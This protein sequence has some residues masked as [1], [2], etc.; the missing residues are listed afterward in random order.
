MDE[1][2]TSGPPTNIYGCTDP[3][4]TNHNPIAR[5]NDGSCEYP[6]Y[7]G[8][9]DPTAT[10]F[11]P[12]ARVNDG[13]CEYNHIYGCTDQLATNYNPNA[14][15]DDGSCQYDKVLPKCQQYTQPICV[16]PK[17]RKEACV[18]GNWTRQP[19]ELDPNGK[20]I[21][22]VWVCSTNNQ[23]NNPNGNEH[24]GVPYQSY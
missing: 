12:N 8:C 3:A 9:T 15:Y 10:N 5:I 4:A 18:V 7:Y 24:H 16:A 22:F 17:N 6:D 13:S 23:G 1:L 14:T 20:P 21:K 11:D 19:D 2:C